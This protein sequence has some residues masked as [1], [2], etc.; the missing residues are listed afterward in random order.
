MIVKY[1]HFKVC[2]ALFD[3]LKV[4]HLCAGAD[5]VLFQVS[6]VVTFIA[7]ALTIFEFNDSIDLVKNVA[8]VSNNKH[9]FA[10]SFHPF[11]ILRLRNIV[12]VVS[13]LIDKCEMSIRVHNLYN[14]N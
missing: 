5:G 1:F 10:G 4:I 6:I 3:H 2:D 8:V 11:N 12:H 9:C 13:W 14:F 7:H